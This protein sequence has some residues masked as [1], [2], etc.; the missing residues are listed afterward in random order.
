MQTL[1]PALKKMSVYMR[2]V[3]AW[4]NLANTKGKSRLALQD[5]R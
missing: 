1:I 4:S 5:Y 2:L 3:F